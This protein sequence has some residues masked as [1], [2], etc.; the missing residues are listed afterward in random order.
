MNADATITAKAAELRRAIN[1][2]NHRYYVLAQPTISDAEYDRLIRELEALESEYPNLLTPDSPTQRVA[3]APRDD[4][5]KVSHD[6]PMMSLANAMDLGEFREFWARCEKEL[7]PVTMVAEPKFD[8]LSIDLVYRDG[9]LE[10]AS[11]RGDG[12]VGED[13]TPNARTIRSVP[14]R[15][16]PANGIVPALLSVRGE[17][18]LAKADFVAMNEKLEEQGKPVYVNPRNSASGSLRQL[19]ARISAQR[20]LSIYLYQIGRMDGMKMPETQRGVLDILRAFGFRVSDEPK[21]VKTLADAEAYYESLGSRRDQ[22]PFEIDGVVF[23][24]DSLTHQREMGERSRTPRWAVAWKFPPEVARTTVEAIDVQVGRTGAITPVARLK[25]VKVGG[26]TVSNASLHNQD[27]ITRLGLDVGDTVEVQRAGDVIPQIVGVVARR[28][29]REPEAWR[30]FAAH[31]NCPA[32]GT[33][34]ERPEG[35]VVARC[36]NMACPAQLMGRLTHFA[37]RNALNIDGLG[38]KLVEQ[39]VVAKLV[40]SPA[41]VFRLDPTKLLELERMGEKKAANLLAAIDAVKHPKLDRFLYALGVRNIGE[42]VAELIAQHFGNLDK[43]LASS[44]AGTLAT[45][46]ES[47][48]GIGPTVAASF[49]RFLERPE[50]LENLKQLRDLGVEPQVGTT[51]EKLSNALE[52][53]VF[54]FTGKLTAFSREDAE[55]RVKTMGGKAAGS[56]SKKTTWLVAGP[57]AGSKL[58]KARELGVGIMDEQEFLAFMDRAL[59]GNAPNVPVPKGAPTLAAQSETN[60]PQPEAAPSPKS[61][62]AK[63]KPVS[64]PGPSLF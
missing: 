5:A 19:D 43:I 17:V 48:D 31:P 22:L 60:S 62:R 7:G 33:A 39:L 36:P 34:I 47:I 10:V 25:P 54:V 28:E 18:Y 13:V 23:K 16:S 41:D 32:C 8:G 14:L 56:V 20:P 27:E 46:L 53:M 24:V 11:T 57:G 6:P 21:H 15:L 3:G 29:G 1:D 42:H 51:V 63:S 49:C 30:L 37:S 2:A 40:A 4:M 58:A 44:A 59:A 64:K 9:V 52:D 50:N 38:E 12:E 35:E 45:D 55:A 61:S 26:V